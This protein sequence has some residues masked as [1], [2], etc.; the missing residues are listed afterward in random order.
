MAIQADSPIYNF[1]PAIVGDNMLFI[2]FTGRMY[3]LTVSEGTPQ[4]ISEGSKQ[5]FTTAGVAVGSGGMAF[6]NFNMDGQQGGVLKA[7]NISNGAEIWSR[8]LGLEASA[9]PAV[10]DNMVVVGMGHNVG[11]YKDELQDAKAELQAFHTKTGEH[12]WTFH[13]VS[14]M[15][16]GSAGQWS[17]P[18]E[19]SIPD[20]FSTPA[21]GSDGN[22]YVG[23]EGGVQYVVDRA[24][25]KLLSSHYVGYGDQGE[26]AI[27]EDFVVIPSIGI[28]R[29]WQCLKIPSAVNQPYTLGVCVY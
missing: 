6:T 25:G 1:M 3:C 22:V 26:P 23:W 20:T 28:C 10:R 24:D 27:A 7:Y 21:I 17:T 19:D 11:G 14:T 12:L 9:A 5:G 18:F 13:T 8:T 2:D 29:L 4:W 15:L 16:H